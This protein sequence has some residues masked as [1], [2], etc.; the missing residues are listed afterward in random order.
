MQQ[1]IKTFQEYEIECDNLECDYKI[2]NEAPSSVTITEDSKQYINMPCPQ[3]GENLLTLEDYLMEKKLMRT[4]RWLNRW[5]S[6]LTL[7]MPKRKESTTMSVHIHE[8]MKIKK[9]T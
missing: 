6:W 3:C 1:L 2:L 7:F 4:I 8:G 5:F 9:E